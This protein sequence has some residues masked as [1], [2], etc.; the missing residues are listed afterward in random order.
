MRAIRV[1][2]A[3]LDAATVLAVFLLARLTIKNANGN[4]ACIAAAVVAFNP[5]LVYVSSLVLSETLFIAML[6]WGMVLLLAGFGF[7][8]GGRR[9]HA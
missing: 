3:L 1:V 7:A 8:D 2:Q 5:M 4:A 6:A 9:S